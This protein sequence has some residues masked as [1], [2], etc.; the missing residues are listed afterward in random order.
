VTVADFAKVPEDRLDL[1]LREFRVWLKIRRAVDDANSIVPDMVKMRL[2][3][4]FKWVNDDLGVADI[5]MRFD[6]KMPPGVDPA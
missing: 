5:K 3:D 4:V 2:P 1:C 6:V